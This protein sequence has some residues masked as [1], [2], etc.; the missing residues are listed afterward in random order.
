MQ[1]VTFISGNAHK[2]AYLQRQLGIPVAH[3]AVALDEIQSLDLQEIVAHKLKEAFSVV[4][5]PVLAEDVSLGFYALGGLPGPYIKWFI[6]NAG[7]AACCKML[8]GFPDR[9]ALITCM[10]GYYDGTEMQFFASEMKGTIS[11]KPR[12]NNGFG[13]DSIF[14][15]DGFS[16]TRAELPQK[17]IEKSYAEQ[18][19][20]FAAVRDFLQTIYNTA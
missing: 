9:S 6:E 11:E 14:I 19:K 20:P 4:K 13:F 16:K 17:D 10:Y 3:N 2:A 5:S 18:M 12:G 1:A 7:T 8:G 15:M